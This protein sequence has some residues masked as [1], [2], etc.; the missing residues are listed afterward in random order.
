MAARA[1]GGGLR[2]LLRRVRGRGGGAAEPEGARG[3]GDAPPP[4]GRPSV[5]IS[6]RHLVGHPTS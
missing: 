1:A 3:L 5:E 4:P 2:A 6:N